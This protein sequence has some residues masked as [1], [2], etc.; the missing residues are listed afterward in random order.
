MDIKKLL[1][2]FSEDRKAVSLSE[3]ILLALGFFLT[4]L[5]TPIAMEQL[6]GA[7]T[8]GWNSAVKTIFTILLPILYI[9]GVAYRY[10]PHTKS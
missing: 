2:K 7:N 10:I 9:V 8:T 5:L 4:A 3:I 1:K 6:V